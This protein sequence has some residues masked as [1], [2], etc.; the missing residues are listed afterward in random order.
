MGVV[1]AEVSGSRMGVQSGITN[2]LSSG[3]GYAQVVQPLWKCH[4][5]HL[6]DMGCL[7][8]GWHWLGTLQTFFSLG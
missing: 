5:G 7:R 3:Q 1:G 8:K 2:P 4:T 6:W